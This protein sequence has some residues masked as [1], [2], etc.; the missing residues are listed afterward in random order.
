MNNYR[1]V[2]IEENTE[3]VHVRNIEKLSFAEAAQAA[4]IIRSK[5]GYSWKITSI[6]KKGE[7][8]WQD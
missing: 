8:T 5:L 3:K 4:Y 1:I 6:S 7:L 2:L